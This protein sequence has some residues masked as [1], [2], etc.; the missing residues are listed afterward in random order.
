MTNEIQPPADFDWREERAY[1]LGVQAYV[2]G[3]PWVYLPLIR[4]L[5]V[6]QP[7]TP[8]ASPTRP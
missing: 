4:W 3:F 1:T 2:F 5:W 6:T 8:S 7:K